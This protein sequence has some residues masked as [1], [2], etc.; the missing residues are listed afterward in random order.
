MLSLA[1]SP[2]RVSSMASRMTSL[3]VQR[4]LYC[5]SYSRVWRSDSEIRVSSSRRLTLG[6]VNL[7]LS[8]SKNPRFSRIFA[9]SSSY[10]AAD[11]PVAG[12]AP[13]MSLSSATLRFT[14]FGAKSE[15]PEAS[16]AVQMSR[17][18]A[19]AF[20]YAAETA[21]SARLAA[22]ALSN[23][24]PHISP[25][26]RQSRSAAVMSA[27]VWVFA[28]RRAAKKQPSAAASNNAPII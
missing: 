16:A 8:S 20:S 1:P 28:L 9:L 18:A 13:I 10:L 25:T 11:A 7:R 23:F 5:R 19:Q 3:A 6:G 12:N 4:L 27:R 2:L 24:A 26:A 14:V 17:S 22:A 15:I 21:P